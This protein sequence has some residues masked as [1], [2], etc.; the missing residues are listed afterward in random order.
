MPGCLFFSLSLIF[1]FL[2]PS[3]PPLPPRIIDRSLRR[4]ETV[5]LQVIS[6]DSTKTKMC[7]MFQLSLSSYFLLSSP[8]SFFT[9][10][11]FL[12][13]SILFGHR[14]LFF[15]ALRHY[16]QHRWCEHCMKKGYCAFLFVGMSSDKKLQQVLALRMRPMRILSLMLLGK[17]FRVH[18]ARYVNINIA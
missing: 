5:A 6:L 8:C 11:P 16:L 12:S 14:S 3:I 13:Y 10:S 7:G 2:E 1:F 17:F 4:Y 18:L 9:L 15:S